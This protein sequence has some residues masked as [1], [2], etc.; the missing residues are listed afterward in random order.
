M[1]RNLRWNGNIGRAP[2]CALAM[3]ILATLVT[4]SG[5]AQTSGAENN[6]LC[7]RACLTG[8]VDSYFK[9]LLAHDARVLPQAAKARVTE[10]GEE[11]ALAKMFW[12]SAAETVFRI[13][14]VNT[15]RGDTGTE[16]VIRNADGSK[17]MYMLRLKVQSGAITEIETIKANK[18][19]AD[20]LWDP[21]RL[22]EV[23]PA[24]KL[25]IRESE[26]DSYYDLIGAAN[27]YWRAFQTN[28][29]PAYHRARLLPD[30]VRF[31]NGVQTTGLVRN[32]VFNDT[33]RGFDEGR[34]IGRNI[35]DRRFPVV[36]EERGVVLSIVRFGLKGGAK[37]QSTA[38]ANDRLVAEFFAIKNGF[39]QEIQ[40]VLFNL[41]DAKSTGWVPDYGPSAGATE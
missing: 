36:D 37:S 26:R 14:V 17:T 25:S 13:D 3:F 27:S 21:D 34:F 33:A 24:F 39:I 5:N 1:A 12:D 23:S 20:R 31:E 30:S 4:Q 9:A 6:A 15:H 2:A 19:E 28:G 22:K 35:W 8:F 40:A 7:D 16:A 11:K 29:T 10:N 41:P 38:T 32:G 18:G